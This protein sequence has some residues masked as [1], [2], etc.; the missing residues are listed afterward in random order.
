ML[1]ERLM[2]ILEQLYWNDPRTP[3]LSK[4]AEDRKLTPDDLDAYW[5][6]KLE[7]A[8]SLLTKSGVG[9]D[10]TALVADGLRGLIDSIATG[11]PFTFHPS[12]A[13]R[14]VEFSHAILRERMGVTADQVENCIKPYKYEVEVDDREWVQGRERAEVKFG[15]EI[16]RCETKLAEIRKRVGGSRRMGGLVGHVAELEKW[17][18]ERRRRRVASLTRKD[19]G[20]GEQDK[21]QEDVSTPLDAY[22]YSSAQIIDGESSSRTGVKAHQ[23][24]GFAD[25]AAGRHALLL[26]NR[27][28]L[29]KMRQHALKSRRCKIGPDESAFCPEAFLSV[30]A[31]KLA[32]TSTMFINIEL[33]EQFFYQVGGH[34]AARPY[35]AWSG[36][37]TDGVAVP[38]GNRFTDPIRLRRA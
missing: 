38:S 32:Y 16:E 7:T 6:Y 4:L 12:A 23:I 11:E 31:D 22:K 2:D 26:S 24:S 35:T 15:E 20:D 10:S 21:E 14:I 30:V 5:K 17:E 34:L 19:E 33:L 27:L 28:A 9:R 36:V 25:L 3:E 29:L 8:S 13:E 37:V 18:E 1:D